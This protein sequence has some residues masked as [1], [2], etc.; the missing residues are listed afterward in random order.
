MK[1]LW[2][3]VLCGLGMGVLGFLGCE[4]YEGKEKRKFIFG[5]FGGVLLLVGICLAIALP[6]ALNN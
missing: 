4:D 3:G 2:K 1:V 5:V 6:I